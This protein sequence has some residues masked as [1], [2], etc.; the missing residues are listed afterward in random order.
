MEEQGN[1]RIESRVIKLDNDEI[2]KI[3]CQSSEDSQNRSSNG[4]SSD[5]SVNDSN[6]N[7]KTILDEE[8]NTFP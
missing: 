5:Q 6:N 4:S 1:Q 3:I 2:D 8:S 7:L